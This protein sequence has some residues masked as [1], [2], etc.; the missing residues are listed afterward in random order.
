MCVSLWLREKGEGTGA[1]C[2]CVCLCDIVLI[3]WSSWEHMSFQQVYNFLWGQGLPG[4]TDDHY[5]GFN[6]IA[7]EWGIQSLKRTHMCTHPHILSRKGDNAARW[8]CYMLVVCVCVYLMRNLSNV[9][10]LNAIWCRPWW[11]WIQLHIL[12]FK[13]DFITLWDESIFSRPAALILI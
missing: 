5:Y 11:F 13:K 10:I 8:I 12:V 4:Y 2:E 6:I 1:I 7:T 9:A 3:E